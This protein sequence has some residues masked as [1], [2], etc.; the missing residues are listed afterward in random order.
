MAKQPAQNLQNHAMYDPP[1]HYF[2]LPVLL[3]GLGKAVWDLIEGVNRNT[4]FGLIWTLAIIVIA[5]KARVYAL[6]VQ[7]R[8]IRLEEQLRM[9]RVL[10]PAMQD[11]IAQLNEDQFIGLRFASDEEL[12]GLG[13]K[14]LA[15]HWKRAEIK[16]EIRNWRPDYFRV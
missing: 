15:N 12:P 16:K 10:P 1:F 11:K 9:Q 8:L 6:K 5:F 2:L 14:T 4:I 3:L 13:E 7:D